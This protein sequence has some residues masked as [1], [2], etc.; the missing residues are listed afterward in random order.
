M[1]RNKRTAIQMYERIRAKL[2]MKQKILG[3]DDTFQFRC[4]QCGKCCRNLDSKS[5]VLSP[6]DV[7]GM[8]K[9]LNMNPVDFYDTYCIKTI[10]WRTGM[11]LLELKP[12]G[13][14]NHCPLLKNNR[15]SVQEAKPSACALY[16]LGRLI[17]SAAPDAVQ[18]RVQPIQCGKNPKTYTVRQWLERSGM[19]PEDD[20]F[21]RWAKACGK[22]EPLFTKLERAEDPVSAKKIQLH[23]R[24]ILYGY[25]DASKPFPE[26]F[27]RNVDIVLQLMSDIP[28]MK[29]EMRASGVEMP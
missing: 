16:P 26:Q 17:C 6:R 13:R 4:N 10:S 28:R 11:P 25:Y 9:A 27:E 23:M 21:I 2:V 22:L 1:N 3:L 18:Y 8:S 15:C 24:D 5:F 20:S 19:D 12:I 29:A 14:D 7:F